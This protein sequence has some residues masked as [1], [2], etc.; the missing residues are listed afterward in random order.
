[1]HPKVG[2]NLISLF[3]MMFLTLK[4][5]LRKSLDETSSFPVKDLPKN[6][7]HQKMS[8]EQHLSESLGAEW[9]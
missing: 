2:N 3:T 1:L 5:L 7:Q 4:T 9:R 6:R 8:T